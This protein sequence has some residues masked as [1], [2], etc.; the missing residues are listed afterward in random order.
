MNIALILAGGKGAR[1][2]QDIP[3]QFIHINNKP[4][5][6]YTLEVFQGH[7][8]IDAIIVVG[9]EG[10]LNVISAYVKQF[11]I[12][13]VRWIVQGGATGHQSIE[14]GLNKL[15]KHFDSAAVC[16]HSANRPL[17][18]Q[19]V[20]SDCFETYRKYGSAV[21]AIPCVDPI[22]ES[23]NGF[24]STKTHPR[25]NIYR[26]QTPHIYNLAELLEAHEIVKEKGMEIPIS[27][28]SLMNALGKPVYLSHGSA[29]NIKITLSE[30][31][32]IFRAFLAVSKDCWIKE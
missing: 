24:V 20:I 8:E 30:D 22:F 4:I 21:A 17:V 26:T 28:C 23:E 16:I 25:D 27:T 11:N 10:W 2:K 6:I 5:L 31:L 19:E 3:K 18:T 15:K 14:N 32:D 13:K 9:L 1:T 29:K 7:T 12:T